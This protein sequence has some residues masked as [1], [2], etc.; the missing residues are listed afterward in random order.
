LPTTV[1]NLAKLEELTVAHNQFEGR[2]PLEEILR[3]PNLQVLSVGQNNFSGTVSK[4][5]N[6]RDRF[7]RRGCFVSLSLT[8]V[9]CCSLFFS[10]EQIPGDV[11]RNYTAHNNKFAVWSMMYN[12]IGGTLPSELG[13][14]TSLKWVLFSSNEF[15]GTIP[16]ADLETGWTEVE[17]FW[18]QKNLNLVGQMPCG[19]GGENAAAQT[20]FRADC[21][22]NP[23][24][25]CECCGARCE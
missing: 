17:R 9:S 1:G 8:N 18:I 10:M 22:S 11:I 5:V 16:T 4:D 7:W 23:S 25:I 12:R 14:I 13:L 3:L 19:D 21:I 6:F 24:L 20:S 2:L 15:T